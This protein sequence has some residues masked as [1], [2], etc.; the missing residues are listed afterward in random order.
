A[1]GPVDVFDRKDRQVLATESRDVSRPAVLQPPDD[2]ARIARGGDAGQREAD[3]PGGRLEHPLYLIV[4]ND[5]LDRVSELRLGH[6][7]GVSVEDA[8]VS[9][10]GLRQRTERNPL[11]VRKA[12]ALDETRTEPRD[13]HSSPP[14]PVY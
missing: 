11:A 6:L 5:R 13:Q 4:R 7:G 10:R 2:L 9:L 14:P 8:G 3:R 1:G 12:T